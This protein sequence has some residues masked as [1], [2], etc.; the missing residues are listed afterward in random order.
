MRKLLFNTI[1]LL[2]TTTGL[3]YAAE[4]Q[5]VTRVEIKDIVQLYF[6]F[7]KAPRFTATDDNRRM[8]LVFQDSTLKAG[9]VFPPPNDD[10][11]K[12]L[13]RSAPNKLIISV[14]FRYKPQNYKINPTEDDRVV[15]EV[16]LGNEYSKS[17]QELAERLKGLT[18]LDRPQV[19][20]TNPL[21]LSPYATDW[22]SFFSQYESSVTITAPVH[23]SSPPFPVIAL[24]PPGDD[25]N[26]ELLPTDILSH[27]E[28]KN[29]DQVA[30]ILLA[31]LKQPGELETKK[32]LALTYGEA[33]ARNN[34]FTGAYKQLYLLNKA[35]P[36]E[37]IGSY[38]R[39]LLALLQATHNNPYVAAEELKPLDELIGTDKRLR[40][41]L[42]VS[43]TDAALATKNLNWLNQLLLADDIGFPR[44]LQTLMDIRQA[45]Y[46]FAI[47]QPVKAYASYQLVADSELMQE[48]PYSRA[49]YCNTLY[50]FK[51]YE[52]AAQCYGQLPGLVT[53]KE[54]LGLIAF[55]QAMARL[56][57][58]ENPARFL[59]AFAQIETAFSGTE[60][61]SRAAIKRLDIQQLSSGE[62][63]LQVA[64]R[65]RQI[66]EGSILRQIRE[67]ALFKEALTYA[68]MGDND[69][70]ISLTQE[71]LR[72]FQTGDVR[73]SA[74]ALLIQRLPLEIKRL[75]DEQKYLEALVLAKK[76]RLY[77]QKAWIS[78]NF[79]IDIAS[80]Y[81]HIGIFDE[82]QRLY[83]YLIGITPVDKREHFYLPMIECTYEDGNYTL[84]DDYAAQYSYNYPQGQYATEILL[85]RIK[86]LIADERIQ[87]ALALMPE[88]VPSLP[89]FQSVAGSLYFRTENYQKCSKNFAD[90]AE[91]GSTLDANQ[92]FMLAES[93]FQIKIF[94]KAQE[95]FSQISDTNPFYH[96]SLYR[97]AQIAYEQNENEKA[98]S[99]LKKLAETEKGTKWQAL[100][101]QELQFNAMRLPQ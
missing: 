49:G 67:D 70:T 40:P 78:S 1:I 59:D 73:I 64:E 99:I 58:A 61:A 97:L 7:D 81:Q 39:Y 29:W 52:D 30:S 9:L 24:L 96:H 83:L 20:Y 62:W 32:L 55:R 2:C 8:D 4:L 60:A 86:S 44:P 65:Y 13:P 53:D 35:Y 5:K 17:Y 92:Q 54:Q 69:R 98:L 76:N 10:I 27:A 87:D 89:D 90:L 45:D 43:E 88:P 31:A 95:S 12:F 23:F 25:K 38:A 84:V 72:D 37:L 14:F 26:I 34:D 21:L 71:I 42:H 85:L 46:W 47:G 80:A 3:A 79:L 101:E 50:S 15:F 82:A 94:D 56:K 63:N 75:V 18:V 28:K 16:L 41:Y 74:Q 66:A 22:K 6:T 36:D 11:V 57:F 19:D 91:S 33:L 100:A 93:Y 51:K 77:F 48:Q 68:M